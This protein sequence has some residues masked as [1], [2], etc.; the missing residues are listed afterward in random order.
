MHQTFNRIQEVELEIQA[1]VIDNSQDAKSDFVMSF[2]DN[3]QLACSP[4]GALGPLGI[5]VCKEKRSCCHIV[6]EAWSLAVSNTLLAV[7][8]HCPSLTPNASNTSVMS[9]SFS[10]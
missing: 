3:K 5:M 10:F 9:V 1:I 6:S 4:S 8:S 7:P 2:S